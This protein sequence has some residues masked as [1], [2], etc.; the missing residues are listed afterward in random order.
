MLLEVGLRVSRCCMLVARHIARRPL[1][2]AIALGKYATHVSLVRSANASRGL[3]CIT[4]L[5][6]DGMA[7]RLV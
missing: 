2:G 5:R 1:S 6:C 7:M 4:Y 3:Y